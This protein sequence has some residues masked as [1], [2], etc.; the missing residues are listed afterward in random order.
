MI[1]FL[2]RRLTSSKYSENMCIVIFHRFHHSVFKLE[3]QCLNHVDSQVWRDVIRQEESTA[4][5]WEN[6]NQR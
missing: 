2:E 1:V 4:A 6:S 3:K 5:D